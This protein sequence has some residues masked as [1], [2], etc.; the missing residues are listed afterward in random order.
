MVQCKLQN[1]EKK[2]QIFYAKSTLMR[3]FSLTGSLNTA[4][5]VGDPDGPDFSCVAL[6]SCKQ[7]PAVF[8]QFNCKTKGLLFGTL[9]NWLHVF[10]CPRH[11]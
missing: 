8:S 5:I 1:V 7:L 10:R 3:R 4:G 11:E 2:L 6:F 9:A